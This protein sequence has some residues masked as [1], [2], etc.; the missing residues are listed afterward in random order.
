LRSPKT[1]K[2]LI[3]KNPPAILWGRP[4]TPFQGGIAP[5]ALQELF[6]KQRTFGIQLATFLISPLI[7]EEQRG[8]LP[9]TRGIKGDLLN[10]SR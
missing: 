1:S 6:Y 3:A 8:R 2:V 9:L 10:D 4:L 5:N 7:A